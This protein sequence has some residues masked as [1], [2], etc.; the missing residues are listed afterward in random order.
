VSKQTPLSKGRTLPGGEWGLGPRMQDLQ[1]PRVYLF[2]GPSS[3][4]KKK[5]GRGST[6]GNPGINGA[7]GR[8]L[9]DK[10]P[11]ER[12]YR[13]HKQNHQMWVTQDRVFVGAER[14]LKG[15]GVTSQETRM[16]NQ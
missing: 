1:S 16:A 2:T 6:R 8:V 13:A 5:R 15:S 10:D 4:R 14:V 12:Q 11:A 9:L 3:T 7:S